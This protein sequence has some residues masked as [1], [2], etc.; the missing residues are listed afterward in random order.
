M[1]TFLQN[2]FAYLSTVHSAE[3]KHF[4]LSIVYTPFIHCNQVLVAHGWVGTAIGMRGRSRRKEGQGI[5]GYNF[6]NS[7]LLPLLLK[8]A[9]IRSLLP[10]PI[11]DFSGDPVAKTL[12]SQRK[13]PGLDPWSGS[14]IPHAPTIDLPR[15][16]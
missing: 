15:Y 2:T 12:S 3:M 5:K 10:R 6:Q 14:Q 11:W 13:R 8:K 1:E 16:N 7:C 9:H 4:K